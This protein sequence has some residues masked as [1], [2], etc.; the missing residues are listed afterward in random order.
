MKIHDLNESNLSQEKDSVS[1]GVQQLKTDQYMGMYKFS[2]EVAGHDG[3]KQHAP[4]QEP[5]KVYKDAPVVVGYSDADDKM[6]KA[7]MKGKVKQTVAAGSQE[8]PN[9]NKHSPI[10]KKAV[11][12]GSS[13]DTNRTGFKRGPRDDERHDLDTPH[14]KQQWAL[15]IN[16][17]I[18]AKDGQTVVFG[19]KER[20]LS[21]RQS[22]LA[23]NPKADVG[24]LTREDTNEGKIKGA[25]GKA[26]WKGY[27]YNG[28][29]DGKDSCVKVREAGSQW[30]EPKDV[31]AQV[32]QTLE[33][34]VEWPLTDVMDPQQVKQLISPLMQAVS[35]ALNNL[36]EASVA[37]M[38]KYF[39]GDEKAK[40]P[41][42]TSTMRDFFSNPDNENPI[43]P[44]RGPV[45]KSKEA[46]LSWAEKQ[47]VKESVIYQLDP[48]N[49]MDDTEV[50]VL[51]GAGR[52]SLAGLR[53]KARRE[54]AQLAKDLEVDH[55]SAFRGAAY[56]IKQ[57]ANTLNTIVAAYTELA[58]IRKKGGAKS[59]GIRAED[60]A[61]FAES[62][63]LMEK[64]SQKYKNSINCSN[65]KGFSQKAHCAGKKK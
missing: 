5:N 11:G 35:Q 12:E 54:A 38:R 42:K 51:G 19:T 14:P 62:L 18:W 15:K 64:W 28:T 26:C 40:D 47:K 9:V 56:N 22:I 65:P 58:D 21:A 37:T 6:T 8:P 17:K 31:L 1:P 46:Y 57:L 44:S 61:V 13:Y 29:K 4:K 43:K 49:P 10:S 3:K 39:A 55:G 45:F 50:L 27:R 53:N 48:T 16:G 20:A 23:R 33:R 59:R 25:D 52:Y 32:L 7:A 2:K 41:S 30:G 63:D 36:D 24:L 34:E 60:A